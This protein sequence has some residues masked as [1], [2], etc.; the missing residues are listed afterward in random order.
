[1]YNYKSIQTFIDKVQA[2][3]ELEAQKVYDK[4]NDEL[5][6]RIQAQIKKDDIVW[7]GMGTASIDNKITERENIGDKLCDVLS[8]L[9]YWNRNIDAGFSLPYNF[10][11]TKILK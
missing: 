7:C 9:Q 3:A 11:K 4:Y 10:T 6:K 1:M 8:S 2:E 5:I